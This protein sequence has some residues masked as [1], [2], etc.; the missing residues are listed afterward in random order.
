MKSIWSK[1]IIVGVVGLCLAGTGMAMGA[2]GNGFYIDKNG[3]HMYSGKYTLVKE[4]N[5]NTISEIRIDTLS[6]N[7]KLIVADDYGFEIY[8]RE[9]VGFSY[10]YENGRLVI[11]E[12]KDVASFFMVGIG[13]QQS[14]IN[15]YLPNS[16][17][18]NLVEIKNTSGRIN[19]D[20]LNCQT[21]TMKQSSGKTEINRLIA[22]SVTMQNS[23]G[24]IEIN[25]SSAQTFDFRM[26]SG[27]IIATDLNSESLKME[28]TSGT[29]RLGGIFNGDSTIKV[30]SGSVTMDINGAERDFDRSVKVTSSG[31][32]SINGIKTNSGNIDNHAGNILDVRV[33]SGHVNLNFLR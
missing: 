2:N 17:R 11:E 10:S 16:A 25:N 13:W 9:D 7:I 27:N 31:H 14:Y 29:A 26:L 28:I 20:G 32:V 22:D 24:R 5:I 33:T 1:I 4:T 18:L 15:I 23:S 21:L 6:A 3:L 12:Q 19:I 8:G 30:G